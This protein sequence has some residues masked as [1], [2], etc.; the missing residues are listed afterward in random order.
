MSHLNICFF[1]S[2]I[3]FTSAVQKALRLNVMTANATA[4]RLGDAK[5]GSLHLAVVVCLHH[6]GKSCRFINVASYRHFE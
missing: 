4:T 6:W 2:F 1:V 3:R 5:L